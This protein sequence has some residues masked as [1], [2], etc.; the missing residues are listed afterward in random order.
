MG[1]RPVLT[2]SHV[3]IWV[4]DLEAM[5]E[6]YTDVLGFVQTDRGLIGDTELVF[7]SQSPNDHHQVV[8]AKGRPHD[9]GFTTVNQLSYKLDSLE[10]LKTMYGEIVKKPVKDL[11]QVSHGNAWSIYFKDPEG[12]RVELFV[13]TPWYAAAV[14]RAARSHE[15]GRADREGDRRVLPQP[16]A[17]PEPRRVAARA[18]GQDRGL[19]LSREGVRRR[20]ARARSLERQAL[21]LRAQGPRRPRPPPSL[22]RAD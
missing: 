21:A 22:H 17:L 6:F 7:L 2:F 8:L 9:V 1:K 5:R 20:G 14:P 11:V 10:T 4:T 13:D 18:Q 3:G 16:A 19:A 15:A 12:N